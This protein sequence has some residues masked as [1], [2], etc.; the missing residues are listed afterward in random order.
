MT[1]KVAQFNFLHF[2]SC[3]K[4]L[5]N[6]LLFSSRFFRTAASL[7]GPEKGGVKHVGRGACAR[8]I[9]CATLANKVLS[10]LM[11]MRNQAV[12]THPWKLAGGHTSGMK[13]HFFKVKCFRS[14]VFAFK[15][16]YMHLTF[17]NWY[18]GCFLHL[19]VYIKRRLQVL[20]SWM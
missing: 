11:G 15:M 16:S 1:F 3:R 4:S 6:L 10:W 18:F 7:I 20:F 2:C 13:L 17:N 19:T 14:A 9:Y 5:V 12:K 8:T